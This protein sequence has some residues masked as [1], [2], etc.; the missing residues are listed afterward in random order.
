MSD[1]GDLA[2][3][4]QTGI[5]APRKSSSKWN[6]LYAWL[7]EHFELPE[8]QIRASLLAER[9]NVTNRIFKDNAWV[10]PRLLAL[11][12][13]DNVPT[14]IAEQTVDELIA[15]FHARLGVPP[16]LRVVLI[17]DGNKL[18]KVKRLT[19]PEG[20]GVATALAAPAARDEAAAE[21]EVGE[22]Q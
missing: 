9:G 13:I 20:V 15:T 22:E 21:T 18:V 8:E 17:F 5:D 6:D 10:N 14:S 1:V 19:A 16:R 4:V 12:C 2:A 7:S 11:V 3:R